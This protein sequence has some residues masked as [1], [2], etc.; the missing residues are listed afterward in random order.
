MPALV[1][2]STSPY[3]R[4][5]LARLRLPF[6]C[7][8]PDVDET[9]RPGE[10]PA[11]LAMRLAR[12]KAAAVA[13]SHPDAWVIGSDQVAELDG[14]PIG[15]AGGRDAAIAQLL[16]M[17]AREVVFHTA[18]AV[19]GGDAVH[20]GIDTTRVRLRALDVDA[21][22]RYVDAEQ[23]WDCAGSF[24]CEGY[25]IALFEAIDSSDPTALVGLPLIATARLLRAAGYML[26]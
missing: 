15:K 17:S 7:A 6:E 26:P 18:V 11:A 16:A 4:D 19:A 10:A 21:I 25:G 1:L 2:A 20:A 3:R 24:K 5:L 22:T 9:P 12:S 23:P 8:R 13:T 14:R